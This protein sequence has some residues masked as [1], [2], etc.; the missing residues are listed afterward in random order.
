MLYITMVHGGNELRQLK[1]KARSMWLGRHNGRAAQKGRRMSQRLGKGRKRLLFLCNSP[2]ST[3]AW[4]GSEEE[5][6][7]FNLKVVQGK[8]TRELSGWN[9]IRDPPNYYYLPSRKVKWLQQPE[10]LREAGR[11]SSPEGEVLHTFQVLSR[12][13]L[14][15]NFFFKC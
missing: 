3:P 13:L 8:W 14:E 7:Q 15:V 6:N 1:Q 9:L 2:G 5:K 4:A 12:K 11:I 10:E